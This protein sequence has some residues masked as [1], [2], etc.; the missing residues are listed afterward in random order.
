MGST[1]ISAGTKTD[2]LELVAGSNVT[3]S[4]SD[5][6][7]TIAASSTDITTSG[8]TDDGTIVRLTTAGNLVSLGEQL[9]ELLD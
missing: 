9:L 8:W 6:K 5:K 3:L 4:T 2:T 1:E 7:I